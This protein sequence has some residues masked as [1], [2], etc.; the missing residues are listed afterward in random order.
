MDDSGFHVLELDEAPVMDAFDGGI[1]CFT[2]FNGLPE[3]AAGM[4][5]SIRLWYA[6]DVQ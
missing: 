2:V 3:L 5:K 1:R 6:A 4:R